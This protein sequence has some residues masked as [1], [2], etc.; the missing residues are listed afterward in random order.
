[1][2]KRMDRN[3]PGQR[4]LPINLGA[5]VLALVWLALIAATLTPANDDFKQYWQA[6]VNLLQSG[7]PYATTPEPGSADQTGAASEA[8][9]IFYPYPPLLAYLIQPLARLQHWQAQGV[10]FGMNCLALSALIWLCIRLSGSLLARRYWGV[11]ILGTLLAPPTRLSLQLGQVSI[12]LALLI[13]AGFALSRRRPVLAGVLLALGSLVKLYPGL[14]G[15]FYVSRCS[16]RVVWWAVASGA[17]IFALSVLAYGIAP[18]ASYL[19]KDLLSESYPY[20]AEF[21]I[22]LIGFWDRLL[23]V[24]NYAQPLL[25]WPGLARTI[26]GALSIGVLA[27]CLWAGGDSG[28]A[29]AR[30][31]RLGVWICAM[32]LLAPVNG[33]YNLVLLLLPLLSALH[34]LERYPERRVSHVLIAATALICIP[35]GWTNAYPAVYDTLHRGAG[36][37]LL[38]PAIYGLTIYLGL[39]ALLVRRSAARADN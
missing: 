26:A 4:Y 29:L 11:V 21:N 28:D 14:L 2:T 5:F 7:D 12:M 32:L 1:M 31:L 37:V 16:R 36:L 23:S 19:R 30:L 3:Q 20:T 6:S 34:Y 17:L 25:V 24:S 10:W 8:I 39:L 33:Y 38:T 13:V 15:L 22:S 9:V 27:I 18:Y 35:P